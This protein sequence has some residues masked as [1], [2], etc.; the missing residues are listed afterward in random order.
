MTF[1]LP[2]GFLCFSHVV[3][4][5]HQDLTRVGNDGAKVKFYSNYLY[6]VPHQMCTISRAHRLTI[7]FSRRACTRSMD[8]SIK[9]DH[10]VTCCIQRPAHPMIGPRVLESNTRTPLSCETRGAMASSYHPD[11]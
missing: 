6:I 3:P 2:V 4:P 9:L 11:T 5:D 8:R 7:P 10:R 1:G